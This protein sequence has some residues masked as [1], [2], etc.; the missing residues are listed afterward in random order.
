[1][2]PRRRGPGWPA[3][4]SAA[5]AAP[6][7]PPETGPLPGI[8]VRVIESWLTVTAGD[9]TVRTGRYQ[10]ITTWPDWRACPAGEPAAGYARRPAIETGPGELTTYPRGPGRIPR[11]R[12]PDLARQELRAFRV[13]YQAI[14]AVICLAAAGPGPDP[15][16][17]SLTAALHAIRRTAEP[18]RTRPD[19]APAQ[20]QAAI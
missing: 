20:A 14:R 12:T 9:G 4:A 15:D 5:A 16:R 2:T 1:M 11:G 18:A 19:A 7:L 3:P 10:L 17:I 6:R 8:T 13:I